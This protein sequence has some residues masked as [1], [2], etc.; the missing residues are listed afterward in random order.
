LRN[1][2]NLRGV[3]REIPRFDRERTIPNSIECE[4]DRPQGRV[5][6]HDDKE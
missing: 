6:R 4:V 1:A 5:N 3:A 2:E